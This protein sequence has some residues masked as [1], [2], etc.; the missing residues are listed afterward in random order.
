MGPTRPEAVSSAASSSSLT[1][2]HFKFT[3]KEHLSN[4][5]LK[6]VFNASFVMG[7]Y[8]MP[9]EHTGFFFHYPELSFDYICLVLFLHHSYQRHAALSLLFYFWS[10]S[11]K[12]I[13]ISSIGACTRI[14]FDWKDRMALCPFV[15]ATKL[16][17]LCKIKEKAQCISNVLSLYLEQHLKSPLIEQIFN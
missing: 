6:L 10:F 4:V 12:E 2:I 8:F 9:I 5:P 14:W 3:H 13:S 16:L 1:L 7:L 11:L 15:A 17:M